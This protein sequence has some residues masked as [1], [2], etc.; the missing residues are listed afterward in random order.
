MT[1]KGVRIAYTA[2]LFLCCTP[3]FKLIAGT[4][5]VVNGDAGGGNSC[6]LTGAIK[7]WYGVPA[8]IT[9]GCDVSGSGLFGYES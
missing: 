8:H 6:Y 3:C 1:R 2:L 5:R 9:Y 7:C 4:T